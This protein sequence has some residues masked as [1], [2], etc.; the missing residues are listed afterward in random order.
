MEMPADQN[1]H[2]TKDH[3]VDLGLLDSYVKDVASSFVL[4]WVCIGPIIYKTYF[5]KEEPREDEIEDSFAVMLKN[6]NQTKNASDARKHSLKKE[7]GEIDENVEHEDRK[8]SF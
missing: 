3:A 4:F 6:V 8:I 5:Q 7:K 2:L 1:E